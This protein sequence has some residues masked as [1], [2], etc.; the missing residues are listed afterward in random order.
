MSMRPKSFVLLLSFAGLLG[1]AMNAKAA[2]CSNAATGNW[3][4]AATW[5]APCNVAGGPTAADDVTIINNTTVT[6]NAAGLAASSVT[7]AT[8]NRNTTL[9]F[10]A[11]SSLAVTNNVTI[12]LPTANNRTKGITVLTGALVVGGDVVL[13]GGASATR[14]ALLSASTGSITING[15]MT[16]NSTVATSASVSLTGAGTVTVN[17]AAGVNNG[18]TVTIGTGTFDVTNSAAAFINSGI[19][20]AAATTISSG[21]L[22]VAGNVTNAAGDAITVTGAGNIL[23]GGNWANSGAFTAGASTVTFNGLAAQALGGNSTTTF[24]NLTIN[25]TAGGVT[26]N[27]A[28]VALSPAVN[29]TLLLTS[30]KL[31]TTVGV[32]DIGLGTAGLVSGGSA[33]SYV[34]GAVLKNYATPGT[35]TFPVGDATNYSP[36]VIQGTAGFTAGSLTVSTTGGGDH[37]SIASSGINP[38]LSVNRYWTITPAGLTAGSAYSATFNYISGSPVDLDASV[39]PANFIV[40]QW[41]GASWFPANS[42]GACTITQCAITGETAFGDFAIGDPLPG[43]NATPGAF[44][45]FEAAT[46]VGV[47]GRIY[48]KIVGAAISLQVVAV[49]ASRT[50]V[51]TTFNTNPITVAML[52]SRDNT[53]AI[54]AATNCRSSWTSVIST[55]ALSPVWTN[56]RSATISITAPVNAWR[57]VRVRVTQGANTG[58]S[59]DRF[60]IRPTAFS[61]TSNA[62][63][64]GVSGLPV[65]KA[66]QNFTLSAN[67]GLTGYD[68]GSGAT[69]ASPQIIP[70]LDATQVVGSPIAGALGGSFGAALNSTATGA[71]FTY[72]EAG[73]FGLNANA[74]YDNVFT[75]VDQPGDCVAA[76]GLNFSNSLNANGQYGCNFGSPAVAL[77]SGFGRFVP[78]HFDTVTSGGMPCPAGLTCPAQ[79][80]GFVYSGEPFTANVYARNAAGATTQNYDGIAGYSKQVTLTAWDALGST[81]QQ[82]PPAVPVGSALGNGVIAAA[83]FSQGATA[84]GTPAAPSYTF[85]ATPIAPTQI[86]IR[87]TDADGVTSLQAPASASIEGGMMI[88]SGRLVISSAY[89]SEFLNLSVP[90]AAQFS[91]DGSSWAVSATDSST[92]VPV[93]NMVFSNWQAASGAWTGATHVVTPPNTILFTNGL[94]SIPLSSPGYGNTG[95]VDLT[96]TGAGTAP[97]TA[98]YLPGNTARITFGVYKGNSRLI[99]FRE[100]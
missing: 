32:N 16:I 53:G 58:C 64:S 77:A 49:N 42:G 97:C 84:L 4:A 50:G 46:P 48:A 56:G 66:G 17:G 34:V 9:T 27:S 76:T 68:N 36:V 92:A 71:A 44:N 67:T 14:K 70:L 100:N 65:F 37:P 91:P 83:S 51:N 26:I 60:A 74:V 13:T 55:Q 45:A 19:A 78:D 24:N 90:V 96:C 39:I 75:A 29:G 80:N 59:T 61:V 7:I 62:T 72:S 11:G 79:F 85:G 12:N 40:E 69:L 5:G 6:V 1:G 52:D 35:L 23:V 33:A 89:G 22:N 25:N 47:L 31:F 98:N 3:T 57:D 15:G 82:N 18:D 41:N 93:A 20:I 94:A 30:G 43:F 28:S 81:T 95:S 99:Y 88:V 73:T 63:N 2:A 86:Y 87:A 10:A 8:G 21:T 38:S 54:T